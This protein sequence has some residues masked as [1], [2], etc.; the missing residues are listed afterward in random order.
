MAVRVAQVGE[1]ALVHL[2][3]RHDGVATLDRARPADVREAAPRLL[4]EH[5]DG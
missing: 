5:L 1:P 4:D 3:V 2:A